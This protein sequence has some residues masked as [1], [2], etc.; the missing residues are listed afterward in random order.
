MANLEID[1]QCM[2]LFVPQPASPQGSSGTM[3][4]LMPI[5]NG[6]CHAPGAD[7]PE[8]VVKLIHGDLQEPRGVSLAGWRLQLGSGR[9]AADVSLEPRFRPKK[10]R[11]AQIVDLT[12]FTTLRV[13]PA[14][15]S[16]GKGKI[17]AHVALHLGHLEK[18]NAEAVWDIGGEEVFMAYRMTW[19]IE[20]ISEREVKW[21]GP[22][23]ETRGPVD[24]LKLAPAGNGDKTIR[25]GIHHQ[26]ERVLD[27][28][29]RPR[30]DPE[31]VRDHFRAFYGMF[32]VQ[33]PDGLPVPKIKFPKSLPGDLVHCG[34][35]R[36]SLASE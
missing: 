12:R 29:R 4:V 28:P 25:F 10:K 36:A 8:H 9:G 7:V 5:T 24:I 13:P 35:A 26:P 18:L 27:T 3:H 15:L 32:D 21:T 14:L 17:N 2:C 16:D 19:R 11:K 1:F 33:R 20:G 31:E 23:G 34:G 30:L 22:N 6:C